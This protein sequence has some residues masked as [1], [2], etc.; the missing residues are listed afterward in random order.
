CGWSPSPSS[1]GRNTTGFTLVELLVVMTIIGLVSAAVI[2]GMP[3][4]RGA[5]RGEALRLAARAEAARER[6]MMDNRPVALVLKEGGYGFEWRTG[7][8]W[9]AMGV[10]PF[11]E[12]SWSEGT[13]ASMAGG[14][15]RITFD[16]TGFA[17]PAR[18]RLVRG[19]EAAEI[20][21]TDGGRV[22]VVR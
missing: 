15:A 6:A 3:D 16:S 21:V 5:L 4:P 20:E 11:I 19:D 10:K 8:E 1:M 9:R 17:E 2:L 14:E 7:G 18:L 12:Q 13:Q 22:H